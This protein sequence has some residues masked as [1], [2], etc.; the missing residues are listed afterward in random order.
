MNDNK[1]QRDR[2]AGAIGIIMLMSFFFGTGMAVIIVGAAV[3]KW[4]VVYL[5]T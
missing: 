3:L 2:R 4:A 1:A 5:F